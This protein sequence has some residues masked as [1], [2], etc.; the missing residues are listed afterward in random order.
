MDLALAFPPSRQGIS[1]LQQLAAAQVS[2]HQLRTVVKRGEAH[3]IGSGTYARAPLPTRAEHLLASGN[4]DPGYVAQ[5]RA[6]MLQV[7]DHACAEARCAAVLW[8]FDMAVEPDRVELSVPP[9]GGRS[10][11][12]LVVTQREAVP[13][14]MLPVLAL[15]PLMVPTAVETVLQCAA[16]LPLAEGVVIADS[17][18]RKRAVTR[19]ELIVGARRW[20]RRPGSRQIRA[21]LR[22]VD[23]RS[24]SVL[25]S[26]MRVLLVT[27]GVAQPELQYVIRDGQA[28]V[29]RVDLCW[30][31]L[32][33]VVETD[34]RRWHD[35][36]DRRQA[37]RR[38]DN[39]LERLSWRVLRFTW[40]EV[41]HQPDYV[42]AMVRDCL[43]GWMAAA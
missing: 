26:L 30:P 20:R 18:L 17:A 12:G 39:A 19:Q 38:R 41:V 43:K 24:E 8:G 4:I 25:E 22:I 33:L 6:L 9:G 11:E 7:G 34:G 16:T 3:R 36:E 35:P 1:N 40:E 32:R 13:H 27:A 31:L 28:F 42:V 37:D 5:V 21:V 10:I 15:E 14:V 23:A 2:R 29:A